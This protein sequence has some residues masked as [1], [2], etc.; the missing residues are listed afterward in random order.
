MT[1]SD[2]IK[3][4]KQGFVIIRRDYQNLTIKHITASNYNWRTLE[5]GFA[6]KAALDR[7]AKELLEQNI[8][9]L[10]K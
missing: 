3:V 8:K 9:S 10:K 5:K 7:R 2:H 1:S 6:S 4:M